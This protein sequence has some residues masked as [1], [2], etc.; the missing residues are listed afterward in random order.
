MA[1]S[2]EQVRQLLKRIKHT[3][4]V[5]MSCLECLDELDRYTQRILD[6]T[7]LNDVLDKVRE[8]LETCPCCAGQFKLVMETLRA[9]EEP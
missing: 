9:I 3:R 6:A 7:P 1:L 2:H 4:E 8:H 5:E